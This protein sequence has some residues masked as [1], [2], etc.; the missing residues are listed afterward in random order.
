MTTEGSV[1]AWI[2]QLHTDEATAPARLH[3]RYR[4]YLERLARKH[5]N[6]APRRAADDGLRG[7]HGGTQGPTHFAAM[8]DDGGSRREGEGT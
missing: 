8:A 4:V 2:R 5:L 3:A 7:R 6:G 1:T